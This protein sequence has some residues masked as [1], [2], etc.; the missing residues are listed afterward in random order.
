MLDWPQKKLAEASRVTTVTIHHFEGGTT[1]PHNTTLDAIV[2]V[3]EAAGIEFLHGD[4]PGLRLHPSS[5]KK[6]R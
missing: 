3:F 2:R 5:R 6:K 1:T 4:A